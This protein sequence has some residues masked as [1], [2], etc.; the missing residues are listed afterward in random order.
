[1]KKTLLTLTL[2]LSLTL[3]TFAGEIPIT[4]YEGCAPGLWYPI[5]QVCCMPDLE[6]PVGRQA[7][8]QPIKDE[9]VISSLDVVKVIL[10][11]RNIF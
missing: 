10:Y 9:S 5:S 3:S 1:M 8:I 6:C 2:S 11:F 4:G 7:S